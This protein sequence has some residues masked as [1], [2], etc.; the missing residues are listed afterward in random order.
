MDIQKKLSELFSRLDEVKRARKAYMEAIK[1]AKIKSEELSFSLQE[2]IEQPHIEI[3]D[4]E[5]D[6]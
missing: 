1:A 5:M 4:Y 2:I 3:L 6:N